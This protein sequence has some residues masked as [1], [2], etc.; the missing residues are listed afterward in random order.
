MKPRVLLFTFLALLTALRLFY[1]AQT[2]LSADESYYYLW[3]QHPDLSYYSKGPGVA[4]AIRLATSVFGANEFG[5]RWLSPLLALGTSLV[6][7]SFAR[8]I[9][10]ESVAIW[11]VLTMNAIPIFNVGALV[12]TIDPLS[13]FLW[14]AALYSFWLALEKSPAFSF[15]WPLTGLLIGLGFLAKYT[16][17]MQLLSIVLVLAFTARYRREFMRPGFWTMLVVFLACTTPV[18][19]WNAEHSWITL[20]HLRS[21]G[22]IDTAFNPSL[23]KQ[24]MEP[25]EFLGAHLG[26]YSPLIFIGMMMALWW[27]RNE[28]THKFKPRF[29]ALFAVPLLVMYGL[30]SLKKAGQANWTAPA[31][32]SLGI[33]ASALWH[34]AMERNA[35]LKKLVIPAIAVGVL[36]SFAILSTDAI[37]AAGIPI[38]YKLDP[39]ARLRG[40][41][42]T[43]ITVNDFRK[44]FERDTGKSA[45]LIGN[46]SQTASLLSFYLPEPRTEGPGHPPVYTP[47][48][49]DIES[50]FAFW[51]RYDEFVTPPSGYKP[52]EEYYTEE[53]GVN[54]F[55]G[56]NALYIS[57][58]VNDQPPSAIERGFER[59]EMIALLDIR[60]RGQLLRTVRI[61]ACYNYRTISL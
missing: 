3:S 60:R 32:I 2:E 19:V 15:H 23:W 30:L 33:L 38:P 45:F 11:T 48:S 28:A 29:L 21:R 7:Y 59:V 46:K 1:I 16:N 26:V 9:Y 31:F 54:L 25:F 6:M 35:R 13:I 58:E 43:A 37:R 18:I 12:M 57:D 41:K 47:E 22:N 34:E 4:M 24:M 36:M 39:G 50:E 14:T 51:P 40:W 8:R 52:A 27:A 10:S 49:Q 61:F 5:V 56:R 44:K 20:T 17:A 42:T 55:T 53:Q